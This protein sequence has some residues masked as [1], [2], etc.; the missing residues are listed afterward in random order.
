MK[1]MMHNV[2]YPCLLSRYTHE[3]RM[4]GIVTHI[5]WTISSLGRVL[6]KEMLWQHFSE[7]PPPPGWS[8]PWCV[9]CLLVSPQHSGKLRWHEALLRQ[10]LCQV[11]SKVID[12]IIRADW[13]I[14]LMLWHLRTVTSHLEKVFV[15]ESLIFSSAVR[16]LW[17]S[18][19][20]EV[21]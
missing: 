18:K 4:D 1:G 19:A 12:Q 15:T 6:K 21:R 8:A 17:Y 2:V 3:L 10:I 11:V 5:P 13:D 7:D 16:T 20:R 9:A 14:Q